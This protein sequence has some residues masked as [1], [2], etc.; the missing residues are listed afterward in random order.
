MAVYC[1]KECQREHCGRS[2]SRAVAVSAKSSA[3]RACRHRIAHGGAGGEGPADQ[4]TADGRRDGGAAT[5]QKRVSPPDDGPC[6]VRMDAA[7]SHAFLP[8][9]HLCAVLLRVRARDHGGGEERVSAR[10]ARTPSPS[11]GATKIYGDAAAAPAAP[12]LSVPVRITALEQAYGLPGGKAAGGCSLPRFALEG[13][14]KVLGTRAAG[15]GRGERRH[16][17]SEGRRQRWRS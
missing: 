3:A 10:S 8:C 2:T 1:S 17:A 13:P 11:V 16:A 12:A 7:Q 4:R 15:D 9:G 5:S 6:C 14:L